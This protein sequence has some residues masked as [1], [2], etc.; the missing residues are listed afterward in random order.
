MFCGLRRDVGTCDSFIFR[1][2]NCLKKYRLVGKNCKAAYSFNG[3]H[4]L[5]LQKAE[6]IGLNRKQEN[7]Q[8]EAWIRLQKGISSDFSPI[9]CCIPQNNLFCSFMALRG[10]RTPP[11]CCSSWLKVFYTPPSSRL[12]T[13]MT[14]ENPIIAFIIHRTSRVT[15]E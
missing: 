4:E 1:M 2:R 9:N 15:A 13:N 12:Q 7:N 10:L 5:Q 6:T 14:P 11:Q 8:I 3:T